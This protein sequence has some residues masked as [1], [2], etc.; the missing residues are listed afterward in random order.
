MRNEITYPFLNINGAAMVIMPALS[1][2]VAVEGVVIT[3]G[4]IGC[5][6]A[7]PDS[8]D[9]VAPTW[10]PPGSCR[11]QVGPMLARWTL[12]LGYLW[13]HQWWQNWHPEHTQVS[14]HAYNKDY[15]FLFSIEINQLVI[16]WDDWFT[17]SFGRGHTFCCMTGTIACP[18]WTPGSQQK[19]K[20]N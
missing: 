14:L 3:G 9:H 5:H 2:L 8:K 20:S 4:V 17:V 7:Y 13:C 10:G 16:L 11:P 1:S 6:N 12:L 15:M 18:K 19:H